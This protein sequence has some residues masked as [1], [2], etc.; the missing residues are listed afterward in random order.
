MTADN[1]SIVPANAEPVSHELP[2]MHENL[3][4]VVYVID[5]L[6][7]DQ[8]AANIVAIWRVGALL[9]EIE[10]N[11]DKYLTEEQRTNH[12]SPSSLLYQVYHKIYTPEQFSTALK[13]HENYPSEKAIEGLI[14]QRC[15][16]KPNWRMT[17]SHVQLLITVNDQEQRKVIENRCVHEAY[18][19]KA[20]S[21]ELSEL[22]GTVK[23]ERGPVAP[24]GLKQQ[25][26]DLLEHQRKF[27]A[28]SEKL[29]LDDEGLYDTLMNSPP[30]K[31]T[32]TIRGYL[33]E[34]AENCDKLIDVVQTH[35]HLGK[36][37]AEK[38]AAAETES[39]EEEEPAVEPEDGEEDNFAA[40][41]KRNHGTINR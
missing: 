29:W 21:V 32:D 30:D 25:V 19:T 17:A 33:A 16:T 24:K 37:I 38:I 41:T 39:S 22:H 36:K 12:V 23:K 40:M 28:R 13:L 20:L 9:T 15:P 3:Q 34:I 7:S 27:I 31:I 4:S 18:T 2:E 1:M 26:Y 14:N 6:M 35:Q 8:H 11:P 5:G 10:T